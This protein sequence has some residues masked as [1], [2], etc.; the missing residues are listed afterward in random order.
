MI[1]DAQVLHLSVSFLMGFVF[2]CCFFVVALYV[3]VFFVCVCVEEV[4]KS[5]LVTQ[6]SLPLRGR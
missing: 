3:Q 6:R 2:C 4:V 1:S 5:S